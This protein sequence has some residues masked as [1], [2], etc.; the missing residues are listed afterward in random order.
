MEC[1]KFHT[2]E[3]RERFATQSRCR[4]FVEAVYRRIGAK[5]MRDLVARKRRGRRNCDADR[6]NN[7]AYA[8]RIVG[9]MKVFYKS[10][11]ICATAQ[12]ARDSYPTATTDC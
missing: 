5:I 3:M 4:G 6:M 8:Q 12:G 9:A 7:V 10:T 1:G 11:G 2:D